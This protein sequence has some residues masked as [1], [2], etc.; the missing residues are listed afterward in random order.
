MMGKAGRDLDTWNTSALKIL[1]E[2]SGQWIRVCT[3]KS[4]G[5]Y[6]PELEGVE[7]TPPPPWPPG[8][9]DWMIK[10]ALTGRVIRDKTHHIYR[11]LWPSR[12][13]S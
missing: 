7:K 1:E 5:S 11:E 12:L 2:Y 10:L 9:F 13:G 6:E 4:N 3:S 8:G